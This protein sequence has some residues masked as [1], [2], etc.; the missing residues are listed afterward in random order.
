MIRTWQVF[1]ETVT[2]ILNT[3]TITKPKSSIHAIT[4]ARV[5]TNAECLDIIREKEMKKKAEEEAKQQ[6]KQEREEK[7]M[8][9]QQ[10]KNLEG[11]NMLIAVAVQPKG[12]T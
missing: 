3:P 8:R 5:L 2:N 6:R 1:T 4:T 12:N 10:Y 7:K 11:S 9:K